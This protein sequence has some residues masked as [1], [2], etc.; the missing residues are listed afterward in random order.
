MFYLIEPFKRSKQK[1]RRLAAAQGAGTKKFRFFDANRNSVLQKKGSLSMKDSLIAGS[2][3]GT[4]SS[5]YAKK[6]F[7]K[8]ISVTIGATDQEVCHHAVPLFIQMHSVFT[9]AVGIVA[10][11]EKSAAD[12]E[13]WGAGMISYPFDGAV[14]LF[15]P[16]VNLFDVSEP[17]QNVFAVQPVAADP[18]EE[19][20]R[21]YGGSVISAGV[22]PDFLIAVVISIRFFSKTVGSVVGRWTPCGSFETAAQ[23]KLQ[24][25]PPYS[26]RIAFFRNESS[27]LPLK[28]RVKAFGTVMPKIDLFSISMRTERLTSQ[29]QLLSSCVYFRSRPSTTPRMMESPYTKILLS[30]AG[31]EITS[32]FL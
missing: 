31:N 11:I 18:V 14:V 32:V 27:L 16:A 10:N 17:Q 3:L 20:L 8:A 15:L 2:L 7:R 1:K 22:P 26:N 6:L 25:F 28:K 29:T 9:K 5:N 30:F 24:S 21:M 19:T 4:V 23:L 12:V 13:D